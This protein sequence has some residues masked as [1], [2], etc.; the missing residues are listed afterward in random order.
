MGAP[1]PEAGGR[2]AGGCAGVRRAGHGAG[3]RQPARTSAG[4]P[5]RAARGVPAPAPGRRLRREPGGGRDPGGGRPPA[6]GVRPGRRGPALHAGRL[7]PAPG[8]AQRP[9]PVPAGLGG[10]HD[11]LDSGP[12]GPAVLDH[13]RLDRLRRPGA[14][15]LGRS[16]T[17]CA[18]GGPT[19][20]R[21]RTGPRG[22]SAS[23]T[24]RPR[25]PRRPSGRGSP[26]S[27]TTSSPTT[28][29]SW[30]CR[31]TGRPTRWTA[32]PSGPGRRWPRS[33]APGAGAGRD[34]P[35]AGRAAQRRRAVRRG[36]DPRRRPARRAAG[37]DPRL[38]TGG[39]LHRAGR[40]G[41]AAQRRGPGRLPD[42]AG[43]ADQRAQARRPGGAGPGDPAVLRGRAAC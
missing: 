22:W 34:A 21:W 36:P 39:L 15:R 40:A 10:R 25:S 26:A 29:A 38:G 4:N 24:P 17:R 31:P 42:G 27:C 41:P 30:W 11:P 32:R 18:T 1:P 13:D 3:P 12:D 9:D 19:M 37:P 7:L 6:D 5:D 35:H 8:L 43:V 2:R 14:D 16:A 20:R 23:A 28:S 33:P